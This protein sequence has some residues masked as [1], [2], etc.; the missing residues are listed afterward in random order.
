[1]GRRFEAACPLMIV[2]NNEHVNIHYYK[3]TIA[4]EMK[5]RQYFAF[6]RTNRLK[7]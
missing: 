4:I 5:R 3:F 6:K 1:M 2:R 7:I